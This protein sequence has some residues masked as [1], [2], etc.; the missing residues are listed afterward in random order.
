MLDRRRACAGGPRAPARSVGASPRGP[1]GAVRPR[2][3]QRHRPVKTA[4]ATRS[5]APRIW[6]ARSV[7]LGPGAAAGIGPAH[8]RT[9]CYF[10][11]VFAAM[12][13]M[14]SDWVAEQ[15]AAAVVPMTCYQRSMVSYAASR[16]RADFKG[17]GWL[18]AGISDSLRPPTRTW[19]RRCMG[20]ASWPA[21]SRRIRA[22][23]P[24]ISV[25]PAHPRPRTYRGSRRRRTVPRT[26]RAASQPRG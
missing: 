24:R 11:K 2:N 8:R 4:A 10:F 18:D 20:P 25:V 14:Q 1:D 23:W 26:S 12:G 15:R 21:C 7:L 3:T 16:V 9:P 6:T 19:R 17:I 13:K 22:P 5:T